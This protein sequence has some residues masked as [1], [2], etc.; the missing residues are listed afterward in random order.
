MLLDPNPLGKNDKRNFT[1]WWKKTYMDTPEARFSV[2]RDSCSVLSKD[3]IHSQK[4]RGGDWAANTVINVTALNDLLYN[5]QVVITREINF[6][7]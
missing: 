3:K 1:G 5:W 7:F 6:I 2:D 4:F